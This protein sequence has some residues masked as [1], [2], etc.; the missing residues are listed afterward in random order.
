MRSDYAELDFEKA[1]L[2][3]ANRDIK[4][5]EQRVRHQVQLASELKASGRDFAQA[6]RL[7][8]TLQAMLTEWRAHREMIRQRIAYLERKLQAH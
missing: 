8:D 3:R 2:A 7:A 4:E 5:G 1:A 6:A